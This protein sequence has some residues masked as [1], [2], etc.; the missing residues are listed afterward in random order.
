MIRSLVSAATIAVVAI[1]FPAAAQ[2]SVLPVDRNSQEVRDAQ[3]QCTEELKQQL[4][5][6]KVRKTIFGAEEEA[7]QRCK[8]ITGW[9]S[10]Q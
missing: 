4:F 1:S 5:K 10:P 7:F 9:Q 2:E 6:E 3:K 8:K